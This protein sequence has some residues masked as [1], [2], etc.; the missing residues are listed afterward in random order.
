M[1]SKKPPREG[2]EPLE[3]DRGGNLFVDIPGGPGENKVRISVQRSW[4][5]PPYDDAGEVDLERA[6]EELSTE[7]TGGTLV[8][9]RYLENG[10][11]GY[12]T[13]LPVDSENDLEQ[14]LLA[15][16]TLYVENLRYD[17]ATRLA[18]LEACTAAIVRNQQRAELAKERRQDR[19]RRMQ[20]RRGRQLL[21]GAWFRKDERRADPERRVGF[22]RRTA[23][24]RISN[25]HQQSAARQ[26]RSSGGSTLAGGSP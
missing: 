16:R 18:G 15:M 23:Q 12:A 22:D 26:R 19:E 3:R 5:S 10:D 4:Y 24:G 6:A 17:N 8:I 13:E 9:R 25:P 7:V 2:L 20:R 14:M 21:G 1:P 11:L